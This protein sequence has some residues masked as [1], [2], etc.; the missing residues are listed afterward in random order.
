MHTCRILVAVLALFL[1]AA[2]ATFKNTPRQDYIWE[3]GRVCDGRVAFWK[4]DRVE[5]DGRFWILSAG[6]V[7]PGKDDYFACMQEGF[8]KTPYRQWLEQHKAEYD[9]AALR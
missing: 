7:P 1:L 9:A 4:M 5:S 3:L 2:C 8:A 6:N